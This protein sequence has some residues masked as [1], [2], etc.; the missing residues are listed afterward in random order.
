MPVHLIHATLGVMFLT[1]WA[2][3]GEIVLRSR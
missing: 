3:I 2:I 1:I